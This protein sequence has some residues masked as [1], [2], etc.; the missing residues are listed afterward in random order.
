METLELILPVWMAIPLMYGNSDDLMI[1][2]RNNLVKLE[3]WINQ[4][5]FSSDPLSVSD[6]YHFLNK[7]SFDSE[8]SYGETLGGNYTEYVFPPLKN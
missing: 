4:Q 6:D 7:P 3:E 1:T 5:G 8:V 2:D